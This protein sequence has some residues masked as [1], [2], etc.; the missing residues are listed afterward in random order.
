MSFGKCH[1]TDA[2]Q[3]RARREASEQAE[4]HVFRRSDL[5]AC[6]DS[7]GVDMTLADPE[8]KASEFAQR[9]PHPFET[10]A[11]QYSHK[12]KILVRYHSHNLLPCTIE[13]YDFFFRAFR[14]GNSL[15][16]RSGLAHG[17]R[18]S[19]PETTLSGVA[20]LTPVTTVQA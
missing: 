11:R 7:S 17:G 5:H 4:N 2:R 18:R 19:E 12:T 6:Y 3:G 15:P 14:N 13:N 10:F 20:I 16:G 9:R 8:K 1:D